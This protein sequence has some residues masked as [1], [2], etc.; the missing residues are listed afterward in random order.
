M[1][2]GIVVGYG[3]YHIIIGLLAFEQLSAA[4]NVGLVNTRRRVTGR[5]K[6]INVCWLAG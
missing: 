6:I 1:I 2:I 3:E 4:E 5:D